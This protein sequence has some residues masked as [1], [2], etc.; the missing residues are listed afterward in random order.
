MCTLRQLQRCWEVQ[1]LSQ[2]DF[3]SVVKNICSGINGKRCRS[4]AEEELLGHLEDTYERNRAI[5]KTM[6]E[7]FNSAVESLGNTRLLSQQLAAVHAHSPAAQMKSALWLFILGFVLQKF[8]LNLFTGMKTITTSIGIFL[9]FM[10]LF[11]MRT[12][13][14]KLRFAFIF[15]AVSFGVGIIENCINSYGVDSLLLTCVLLVVRTIMNVGMWICAVSGFME[16]DSTYCAD[17]DKKKPYL[18]FVLVYMPIEIIVSNGL[19]LMNEGEEINGE[20]TFLVI[21]MSIIYIFAIAQFVRLK[22]RLWDADA[23]YGIDSWN[24]K[25]ILAV[26]MAVVISIVCP[27]FFMYSYAIKDTPKTALEIHDTDNQKVAD[28]V[29]NQM[30]ELG[31]DATVLSLLPDSEV[32]NYK[33][34]VAMTVADGMGYT[35][36]R[37]NG[38]IY[39]F[40]FYDG[41]ADHECS[42]RSLYVMEIKDCRYRAGFYYVNHD[43]FNHIDPTDENGIFISILQKQG[44]KYYEKKPISSDFS[45]FYNHAS[46]R[47]GFDFR[48][49][50]NQVVLYAMS[51][52][53]W[54]YRENFDIAQGLM[55]V[56]Q[57]IPLSFKYNTVV[58][59]AEV[60]GNYSFYSFSDVDDPFMESYLCRDYTSFNPELVGQ[61]YEYETVNE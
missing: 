30:L 47:S 41:N 33:D 35:D 22:N 34:A 20:G 15:C 21:L 6:D 56:T 17:S 26:C 52:N 23:R 39:N 31:M 3:S 58:E 19:V 2:P 13:N 14:K 54:N 10:S 24:S 48:A 8:H 43:N 1:K 9:I 57:R 4:E 61:T 28:E 38:F 36:D 50:E 51:C 18:V 16:M 49:E 7:A 45:A 11:L 5:G 40:Y 53:L 29:R 46:G 27:A 59:F 60:S 42:F 25:S 55:F 44:N 37:V 12:V 32:M